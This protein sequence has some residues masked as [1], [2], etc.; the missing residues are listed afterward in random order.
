M[1]GK[2]QRVIGA[3]GG[4][5]VEVAGRVVWRGRSQSL[6]LADLREDNFLAA[7][8]GEELLAILQNRASPDD[9]VRR[10]LWT[11]LERADQP[12]LA[13]AARRLAAELESPGLPEEVQRLPAWVSAAFEVLPRS[14]DPKGIEA[15][16]RV[17]GNRSPLAAAAALCLG[18]AGVREAAPLLLELVE[19]HDQEEVF[20]ERAAALLK[21]R[22]EERAGLA[23]FAGDLA[24]DVP[25]AFASAFR[26]FTMVE[27]SGRD[28]PFGEWVAQAVES[29]P[30]AA[31][32][33]AL[34]YLARR[35][36]GGT[37]RL[38]RAVAQ[39]LGDRRRA[40]ELLG[41]GRRARVRDLAALSAALLL[42]PGSSAEDLG[43]RAFAL[44]PWRR[45]SL[46]RKVQM[47]LAS[48]E[49][50]ELGEP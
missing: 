35:V 3:R 32:L 23:V 11:A 43:R 10:A 4:V 25:S 42:E 14:G 16:V 21:N 39:H 2:Q 18:E 31:H 48:G 38:A 41:A 19:N 34:L 49:D 50:R 46:R 24:T 28:R 17:A 37:E 1:L 45:A 33:G 29:Q 5:E 15:V 22:F 20:R 40:R 36:S 8:S 6:E 47:A 12:A 9:L 30:V 44:L 13:A 27:E 7:A 26:A